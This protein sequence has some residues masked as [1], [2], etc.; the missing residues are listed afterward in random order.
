MRFLCGINI[1]KM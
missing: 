1:G